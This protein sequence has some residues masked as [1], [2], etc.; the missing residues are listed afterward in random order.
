MI[1][2]TIS[3]TLKAAGLEFEYLNNENTDKWE[4]VF[5]DLMYQPIA[6]SRHMNEYYYEYSLQKNVFSRD[7][8]M[9]LFLDGTPIGIWPISV[10]KNG[11][12]EARLVSGSGNVLPPSLL[13]RASERLTKKILRAC[14]EI[15][16]DLADAF[17]VETWKICTSFLNSPTLTNWDRFGIVNGS[18]NEVT[19]YWF[20]NLSQS[21]QEIYATFRKSYR[22]LIN[23]GHKVWRIVVIDSTNF[24]NEVCEDFFKLHISVSGRQ[25]RSKKTWQK[26]FDALRSNAALL[27]VAYDQSGI[28]KGGAFFHYTRDESLYAVG[29]YSREGL[30]VPV[31]HAIQESAIFALKERK[32]LWHNLGLAHI[33]ETEAA[34]DAKE[35]SISK[36]KEGF[37]SNLVS[38]VAYR[39]D[40][41]ALQ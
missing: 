36:F 41:S 20:Q 33:R 19:Y 6:Y 16:C 34:I 25:T 38:N 40:Q 30:V 29:A 21:K 10:H 26:Q 28:M 12:G 22:N 13:S 37:A 31:S 14:F 7:F 1:D 5:S 17:Q 35:L 15:C 8:S 11:S 39:M 23:N 4:R 3:S 32:V 18:D 2:S 24:S 9:I 27:V